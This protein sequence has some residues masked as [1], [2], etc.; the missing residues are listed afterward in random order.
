[1]NL[2]WIWLYIINITC[3]HIIPNGRGFV[4]ADGVADHLPGGDRGIIPH[5]RWYRYLQ[6]GH[7]DGELLALLPELY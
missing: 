1:M 6:F 7:I 5:G 4:P 3:E 2:M